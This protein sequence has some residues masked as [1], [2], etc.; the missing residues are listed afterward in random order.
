MIDYTS[1][2]Q[3]IFHFHNLV[4]IHSSFTQLYRHACPFAR[5]A[6]KDARQKVN[7]LK[8]LMIDVSGSCSVLTIICR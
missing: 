8:S 7:F 1:E 6:L 4:D 3:I 5:R 2:F